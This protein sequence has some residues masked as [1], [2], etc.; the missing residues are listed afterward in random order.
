MILVVAA[1]S[2]C[3]RELEIDAGSADSDFA[4]EVRSDPSTVE[5]GWRTTRI[6]AHEIITFCPRCLVAFATV[7]AAVDSGLQQALDLRARL[8]PETTT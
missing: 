6:D 1:C 8:Y 4:R 7:A 2:F 3:P 5:P